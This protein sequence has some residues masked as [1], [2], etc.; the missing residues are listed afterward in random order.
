[1]RASLSAV[2]LQA[3]PVCAYSQF[4]TDN[5]AKRL[6]RIARESGSDNQAVPVD[7]SVRVRDLR[8]SRGNILEQAVTIDA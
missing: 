4:T 7:L 3:G 8:K 1:M 2:A 6:I 5:D